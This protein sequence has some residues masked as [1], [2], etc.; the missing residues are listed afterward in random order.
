M[1]CK[2][3]GSEFNIENFDICPYCM[4]P[5][6]KKSVAE[7]YDSEIIVKEDSYESLDELEDDVQELEMSLISDDMSYMEEEIEITEADLIEEKDIQEDIPIEELGLSVRALNAFRRVHIHTLNQLIEF[8][9]TNN[10]SEMK[11]VGAK[12]VQETEKLMRKVG[13]GEIILTN[14]EKEPEVVR[15]L[16]KNMSPDLDYLSISALAELGFTLKTISKLVQKG[17]RCCGALRDLSKSEIRNIV[18]SRFEDKIEQLANYLEMDIIELTTYVLDSKRDKREFNVFLRR[19]KGETLQEIANNPQGE[20][21]S[22]ITRERVRQLERSCLNSIIHYLR[23]LLYIC[24]GGDKYISIQDL[25]EIFND[26]EYDQ[27][28]LYACKLIDEFEYLDFAD[29]VIEKRDEGPTEDIIISVIRDIVGNGTD[30]SACKNDIEEALLEQGIDYI[31]MEA[32]KNLLKKYN[33]SIY[34]DFATKGKGHYATICMHIIRRDFPNGIKLSQHET[35]QTEDLMKLREIAYENYAG[36]E[37][38]TSDRTLSSNLTRY[39]LILCGRGK[40]IPEEKVIIDENIMSDIK[41]FIDNNEL[42]RVFYKEIYAEFEGVLNL[43]CGIDNYNYLHGVLALR[44]PN[45]Y[46]YSRD[47][48]LKKGV[49]DANAESISDRI[50]NYICRS[51]RPVSKSELEQEFKGFSTVMLT[52]AFAND[53]RLFQW[54][55]NYFACIGILNVTVEDVLKIE[56]VLESI[57]DE[58]RGYASAALLYKHIKEDY[59]SFI[60][61]NNIKS[62]MNLHYIVASLLDGKMDFRRPHIARKGAID[63]STTKNVILYLLEYPEEFTYEEYMKLVADMGWSNVTASAVLC[64]IEEDYARLS[65]DRYILK[66]R[67]A[68]PS[69]LVKDVEKVILENMED[70]ILPI[71]NLDFE[72]FPEWRYDWNEFLLEAVIKTHFSEF[73]IVHPIMKDRRYQKGILVMKNDALTSY[74]QVVAKKMQKYGY[75]R[76]SESQF[77]SF[78]IVNNL[79]RKAIPNELSNNDYIRKDG[80]YYIVV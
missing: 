30:L 66:E 17:I 15:Y 49:S 25:L 35:E 48:L 33:Y 79:S 67:V 34:G 8:L 65:V 28:L 27:V 60:E 16:F 58:N 47:Y 24:K 11:N 23:E 80:D 31:G 46:E 14:S 72:M 56:Q 6:E 38:P 52:N 64:E 29:I 69:S 1:I 68:I 37:L 70:G 45:E 55:Y 78:L 18:G 50:Y 20:E 4:T 36:I 10:I 7:S 22:T 62:D 40:Y 19:A 77:L 43:V 73:E 71:S 41:E 44:F 63:L 2:V 53:S 51:G 75:T 59:P 26:D 12:T 54:E 9:A 21:E 76:L 57:F 61:K 32:V 3:C 5:V 39:G 13:A 42:S 74:P